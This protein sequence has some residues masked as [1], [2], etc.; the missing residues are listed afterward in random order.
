[1]F[2]MDEDQTILNTPLMDTDE[3]ELTITPM[4][5]RHNLNL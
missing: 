3:E 1:M 4:E 5:A 2:Y